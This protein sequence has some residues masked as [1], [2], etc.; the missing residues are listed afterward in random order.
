MFISIQVASCLCVC[1]CCQLSHGCSCC[2]TILVLQPRMREGTLKASM[3]THAGGQ[4]CRHMRKGKH[5]GPV[6]DGTACIHSNLISDQAALSS[7]TC[8]LQLCTHRTEGP[9]VMLA[10]G[11]PSLMT[12]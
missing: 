10:R 9:I 11:D 5:A 12:W 4:A 2:H 7:S 8:S 3:P 6:L 1:L